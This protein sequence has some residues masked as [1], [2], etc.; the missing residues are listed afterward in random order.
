MLSGGELINVRDVDF[1][2][3]RDDWLQVEVELEC[4]PNTL[5]GARSDRHVEDIRVAL[6][7]VFERGHAPGGFDYYSAEVAIVGMERGEDASVYFFLPGVIVSRDRLPKE[8]YFHL[9]EVAVG[10][11]ALPP[12]EDGM[13][14][15]FRGDEL[16]V[17]SLLEKAGAEGAG[18][19]D[20][21]MPSYLAP[22]ARIGAVL[23]DEPT[24]LR[25]EPEP[26]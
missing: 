16:A 26:R 7:M 23:K 15:R 14:R 22:T 1:D 17:A 21:L 6:H 11:R 2:F 10:G 3:L 18:N 24:Y 19:R 20:L 9:V 4:G 5:P 12:D 13:G 8:P 25:R